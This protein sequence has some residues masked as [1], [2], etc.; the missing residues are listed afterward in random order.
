MW[1]DRLAEQAGFDLSVTPVSLWAMIS[2]RMRI[3]RAVRDALPHLAG[4]R[5]LKLSVL[6]RHRPAIEQLLLVMAQE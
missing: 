3:I 6:C 2:V 1:R 5:E 4:M